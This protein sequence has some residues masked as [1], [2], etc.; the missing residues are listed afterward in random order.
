[1]HDTRAK[2]DDYL[3]VLMHDTDGIIDLLLD[4]GDLSVSLSMPRKRQHLGPRVA[5]PSLTFLLPWVWLGPALPVAGGPP[6]L[7]AGMYGS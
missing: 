1:V 4:L 6:R 7:P 3:H 5:R 2:G